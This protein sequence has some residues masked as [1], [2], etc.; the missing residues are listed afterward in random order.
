MLARL[1]QLEPV[2]NQFLVAESSAGPRPTK[3]DIRT[4]ENE[5]ATT[6]SISDFSCPARLNLRAGMRAIHQE[7]VEQV[8]ATC[9]QP[10]EELV[11]DFDATDHLAC[12]TVDPC[13]PAP[14]CPMVVSNLS[15]LQ[16]A[17]AD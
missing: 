9:A 17:G 6:G 1:P 12:V 13:G 15:Q 5:S 3:C 7:L 8:I 10:P 2:F 11:P 14:W 16:N 4:S